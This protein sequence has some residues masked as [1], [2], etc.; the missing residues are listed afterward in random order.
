MATGKSTIATLLAERLNLPSVLQTDV[1]HGV[2]TTPRINADLDAGDTSGWVGHAGSE[3][4][5]VS[6]YLNDCVPVEQC[7]W[8]RRAN[9]DISFMR[10]CI[11]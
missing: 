8:V 1:I 11:P 3:D 4:Q 7:M 6:R 10:L 9:G 2:V 5:V